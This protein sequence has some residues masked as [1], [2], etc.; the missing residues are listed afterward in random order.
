MLHGHKKAKTFAPIISQNLLLSWVEFGLLLRLSGLMVFVV[1]VSCSVN[2]Q[3]GKPF[4][5]LEALT[6][7]C[8]WAFTDWF[9][10]RS[11]LY[12]KS[13]PS[14][15]I[16]LKFSV[17]LDE[18]K[19]ASMQSVGLLKFMLNLLHTIRI[20]GRDFTYM[21]LWNIPLTLACLGT[22]VNHYRSNM[23]WG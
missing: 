9:Y 6:L 13:K 10:W 21:M 3:G 7:A 5:S 11:Q 17:S 12:E 22:L 16:F 2:I 23:V 14:V 19:Q 8:I 4:F 20:Q 18:I 15:L 1:I